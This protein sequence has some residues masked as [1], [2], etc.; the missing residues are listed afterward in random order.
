MNFETFVK[1]FSKKARILPA[2]AVELYRKGVDR[3]VV[4][5]DGDNRTNIKSGTAP[6]GRIYVIKKVTK[7]TVYGD[8]LAR[9]LS[10]YTEDGRLIEYETVKRNGSETREHYVYRKPGGFLWRKS[11]DRMTFYPTLESYYAG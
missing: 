3:N 11:D 6:D 1:N 7:K 4:S 5:P 8:S 2:D 9:M 10:L